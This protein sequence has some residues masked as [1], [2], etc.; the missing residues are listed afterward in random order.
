MNVNDVCESEKVHSSRYFTLEV[1]L[2]AT[3]RAAGRVRANVLDQASSRTYSTH[4]P[5]GIGPI[6]GRPFLKLKVRPT[7]RCGELRG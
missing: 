7:P 3:H 1:L 2:Q 6:N 4:V 5:T